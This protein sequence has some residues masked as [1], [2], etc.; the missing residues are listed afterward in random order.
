MVS[1]GKPQAR[2]DAEVPVL[3]DAHILSV[4]SGGYKLASG[5]GPVESGGYKLEATWAVCRLPGA[6]QTGETRPD[7]PGY[8]H[9]QP[10]P[11][12]SSSLC[13]LAGCGKRLALVPVS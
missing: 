13:Q 11:W 9:R 1:L 8:L 4:E 12:Q 3:K 7:L 2:Q 5:I 10:S 6:R